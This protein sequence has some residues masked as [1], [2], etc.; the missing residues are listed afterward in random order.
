MAAMAM[1]YD[2]KEGYKN[3]LIFNFMNYNETF[4]KME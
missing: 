2:P 3:N 4:K 1:Y